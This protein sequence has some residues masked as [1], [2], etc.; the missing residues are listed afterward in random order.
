MGRR[1]NMTFNR[2]RDM[3]LKG[4]HKGQTKMGWPAPTPSSNRSWKFGKWNKLPH[5][6]HIGLV[7]RDQGG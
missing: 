1:K 5:M 4:H 7:Q 3:R 2:R 6:M